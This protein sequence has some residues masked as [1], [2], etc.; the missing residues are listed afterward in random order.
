MGDTA[1]SVRDLDGDVVCACLLVVEAESVGDQDPIAGQHEAPARIVDERIG[2]DI[3]VGVRGREDADLAAR[4]GIFVGRV[5]GQRQVGRGLVRRRRLVNI[6]N[7][8]LERLRGAGATLVVGGLH[9]DR[10]VFLTGR[11]SLVIDPGLQLELLVAVPVIDDLEQAVGIVVGRTVVEGPGEVGVAVTVLRRQ[12][13]REGGVLVDRDLCAAVQPELVRHMVAVRHGVAGNGE[14][15]HQG[16]AVAVGHP[17]LHGVGAGL[18]RA[19]GNRQLVAVPDR[20]R[21]LVR[22][23]HIDRKAQGLAGIRVVRLQLS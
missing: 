10:D 20:E 15:L 14:V 21:A 11:Q 19:R 7:I 18:E 1:L 9:I 6:S 12:R 23:G 2:E 8:D 22:V 17:H 5:S 4:H 13:S 3:V 16:T